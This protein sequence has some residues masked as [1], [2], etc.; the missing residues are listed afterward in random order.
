M[1][2]LFFI[3]VIH[4]VCGAHLIPL[5]YAAPSAVSHQSRLDIKHASFLS[6]P[7]VYSPETAVHVNIPTK[8]TTGS[9]PVL[10]SVLAPDTFMA[11][12]ALTFYHNL[13]LSR[14]LENPVSIDKAQEEAAQGTIAMIIENEEPEK[15]TPKVIVK[16]DIKKER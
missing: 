11:P 6:T 14:A 4:Q 8:I 15:Q 3:L 7:I 9:H 2:A 12:I 10:T 1:L 16:E 13:P 5:I